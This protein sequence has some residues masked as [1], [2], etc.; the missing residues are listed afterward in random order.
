[1]KIAVLG[2]LHFVSP[3]DVFRKV[4]PNRAHFY[5][6]WPSFKKLIPVIRNESP[7][8]IISLGDIVDWYSDE[9][10]DFAIELMEELNITWWLT[11]GN[12]DFAMYKF[13]DDGCSAIHIPEDKAYN[14]TSEGWKQRNITVNNNIVDAGDIGII[15]MNSVLTITEP[16]TEEWLLDSTKRFKKNILFTHRP[17]DAPEVRN[18]I[19]SVEPDKN[20][21]EYGFAGSSTLFQECIKGRIDAVYCGHTHY[22]GE[23]KV[24]DMPVTIMSISVNAVNKTYS[25]MGRVLVIDTDKLSENKYISADL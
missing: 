12:H 14:V 4:L 13:E 25:G 18:L 15:L 16:G 20:I 8:M 1:M 10:R 23:V 24:D 9:N 2:D 3:N 5:N 11:P 6:A 22:P 17:V 21:E 19:L 7:D